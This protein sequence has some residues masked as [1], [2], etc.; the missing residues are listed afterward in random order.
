[1]MRWMGYEFRTWPDLH[2]HV[3][4]LSA[5]GKISKGSIA[6]P[7]HSEATAGCLVWRSL[8]PM[9]SSRDAQ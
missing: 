2:F 9:S 1:M 3:N 5:F 8:K 6:F 7:H 4:F